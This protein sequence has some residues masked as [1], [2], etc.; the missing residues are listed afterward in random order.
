MI[1]GGLALGL[2]SLRSSPFADQGAPVASATTLGTGPTTV[3]S[4]NDAAN[5]DAET[6]AETTADAA[7]GAAADAAADAASLPPPLLLVSAGDAPSS[8]VDALLAAATPLS[9]TLLLTTTGEEPGA[10]APAIRF[11]LQPQG[12][13]VYTVTFAAATRFDTIDLTL[14]L[15]SLREVWSGEPVTR[16]ITAT[17][18][19][20]ATAGSGGRRAQRAAHHRE[21]QKGRARHAHPQ[22]QRR[23]GAGWGVD[24]GHAR[25]V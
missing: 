1:A 6:A 5:A 20:T 11:S 12:A 25:P 2:W 18:A 7:A 17:Q 24:G 22:R 4:A 3:A 13:P 23:R 15:D 19:T 8:M 9:T 21:Q 14:S 10:T 16:P